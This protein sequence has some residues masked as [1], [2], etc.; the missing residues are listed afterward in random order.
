ME[1]LV[2]FANDDAILVLIGYMPPVCL[3]ESIILVQDT[4]V[5]YKV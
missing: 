3:Q 2:N 1:F 4:R 5:I